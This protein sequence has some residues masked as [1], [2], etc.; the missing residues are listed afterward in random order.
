M[1]HE[2][3]KAGIAWTA[4]SAIAFGT[5]VSLAKL[6]EAAHT[7]TETMLLIRF[8][9]AGIAM[10]AWKFPVL[11]SIP[12][13]KKLSLLGMGSGLYLV[14]SFCFFQGIKHAPGALISILLF[15]YPAFVAV[16]SY[17]LFKEKL[18]PVKVG[19]LVLAMVGAGLAIGPASGGDPLGI[20]YGVGSAIFYSIYILVGSRVV[21]GIDSMAGATFVFFG[22]ALSYFVICLFVG[23]S[24]P[25]TA[26]GWT[27]CV[28]LGLVSVIA[29][30]GFLVGI[31]LIGAVNAS[32][33]SALEPITTAL[34]GAMIWGDRLQGIQWGGGLLILAA[35]IW[36]IRS[37]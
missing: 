23:Y 1:E 29:L 33:I 25:G 14:Q 12:K 24:M 26:L 30:G 35:V 16:G 20:F 9:V 27:G 21:K 13:N 2:H 11:A 15:L 22:A 17:F 34:L 32:T 28:G 6:A 7:G 37:K 31:Q 19:A 8:L 18:S 5:M 36:L 10:A 3:R 4:A